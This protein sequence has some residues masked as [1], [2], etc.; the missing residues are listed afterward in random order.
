MIEHSNVARQFEL[1]ARRMH[2]INHEHGLYPAQWTILR[3]LAA[4]PEE[5]RTS[6]ETARYQHLAVGAVTRT[7]RTLITKGLV[8][9]RPSKVHHRAEQLDLTERGIALLG[10]DPFHA[11]DLA[12]RTLGDSDRAVFSRVLEILNGAMLEKEPAAT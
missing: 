10:S 1:C 4:M 7:V 2:A 12:I 6:A 11:V 9:K 5:L 8:S 3:Y